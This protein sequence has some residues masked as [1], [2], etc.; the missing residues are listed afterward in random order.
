MIRTGTGFDV[1]AFEEGEGLVL[2]GINIPFDRSLKAH[3]DGDV[4]V[5]ALCDALLGAAALGDL[6][7]HFPDTEARYRDVSS[8]DLLSDVMNLLT[9]EQWHLANADITLIAEAP[10]ILPHVDAMIECLSEVI[11][12]LPDQLNIKATTTEMLGFIGR[13]EGIAC[14]ASVLI[15]K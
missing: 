9:T 1:H 14:Q 6:G 5:H 8:L 4:L 7:R 3:S 11:N 13:R 15:Q 2:G 12:C 10:K